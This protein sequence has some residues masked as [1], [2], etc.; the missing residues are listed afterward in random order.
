MVNFCIDCGKEIT[1]QA[2]RCGSCAQKGKNISDDTRKKL[3]DIARGRKFT[4]E[5]KQ[6]MSDALKGKVRSKEHCK[7]ISDAKMGISNSKCG[8]D[9][10]GKNNPMFGKKHNKEAIEKIRRARCNQIFPSAKTSIELIVEKQL[11]KYEISYHDQWN[12]GNKF[13]CDFHCPDINLIIECDGDYWHSL[14]NVKKRDKAKDAYAKVCGI[15]M[16]RLPEHLINN[17]NFDLITHLLEDFEC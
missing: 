4:E 9:M 12:F 5:H 7:H 2:K 3:G 15:S 16:L 17:E 10:H 13:S 14:N 1:S 8:R 11:E 6:K